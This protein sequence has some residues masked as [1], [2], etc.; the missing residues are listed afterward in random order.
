MAEATQKS[1]PRHVT[2]ARRQ[3]IQISA[4]NVSTIVTPAATP[5]GGYLKSS[6]H[7]AW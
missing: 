2:T 7:N 6:V 5:N 1:A 3:I 4:G